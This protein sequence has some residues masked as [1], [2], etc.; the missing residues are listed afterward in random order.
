MKRVLIGSVS[1][2]LLAAM[3]MGQDFDKSKH[4]WL[5]YKAGTSVTFK[6]TYEVGE[7]KQEG[8]M[9]RTLAEV[10]EN[11]YITKTKYDMMGQEQEREETEQF[12]EKSG[13]E[14]IKVDGKEL[15]CTVWVS[16]GKRG[17]NTSE[18]K[19]WIPEGSEVPVKITF[20]VENEEDG[21]LT[22]VKLSEQV[23]VGDKKYTC[24]KLEGKLTAQMG[25]FKAV[26]YASGDVPGGLVKMTA[27]G[28]IQGNKLTI[29]NE[30]SEVD[31]KK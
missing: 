4:P 17:E 26:A 30:V 2:V 16:K 5:K 25:E 19:M 22:A 8:T 14:T 3:A 29:N 23:T 31:I 27:D 6:L 20:K 10:K 13:T 7:M 1:F 18:S 12:P 28:E 9:K 11:E 15:K 21:E 24:V